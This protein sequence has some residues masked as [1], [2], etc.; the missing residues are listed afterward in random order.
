MT[1]LN[2]GIARGDTIFQKVY[3]TSYWFRACFS[4]YLSGGTDGVKVNV[5]LVNNGVT[6]QLL[7]GSNKN[8]PEVR[9]DGDQYECTD[10]AETTYSIKIRNGEIIEHCT[11]T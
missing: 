4:P 11:T 10:T 5:N 1:L 2:Y 7:F 3:M 6:K 9:I 8:L